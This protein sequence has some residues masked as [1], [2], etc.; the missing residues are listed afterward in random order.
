MCFVS[1]Q[2]DAGPPGAEGEQ[3]QE[4]VRVSDCKQP[5]NLFFPCVW[6]NLTRS[7]SIFTPPHSEEDV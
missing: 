4:G 7:Y 5:T 3:G 6:V 2:G 1:L